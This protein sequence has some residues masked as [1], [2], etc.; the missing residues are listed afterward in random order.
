MLISLY[1]YPGL[2]TQSL[3]HTL[4]SVLDKHCPSHT[5]AGSQRW[6]YLFPKAALQDLAITKLCSAFLRTKTSS[7]KEYSTPG[8]RADSHT[9]VSFIL[10]PMRRGLGTCVQGPSPTTIWSPEQHHNLIAIAKMYCFIV[11]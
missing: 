4:A 8:V 3:P 7:H 6:F 5:Q 10:V 11:T 9:E 1:T 2:L